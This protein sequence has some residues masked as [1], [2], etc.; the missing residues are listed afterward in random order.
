MLAEN[1]ETE[2]KSEHV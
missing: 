1:L 2:Q